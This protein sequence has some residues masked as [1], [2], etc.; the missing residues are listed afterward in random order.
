LDDGEWEASGQEIAQFQSPSRRFFYLD[1]NGRSSF[2][3]GIE[4]QS[5]SRRFFY[6]DLFVLM[7]IAL[8][9]CRFNRLR[10]DSFIWTLPL[11]AGGYLRPTRFQSPSRRFFYLDEDVV[12]IMGKLYRGFQ[13]PSRRFFY[14]DVQFVPPVKGQPSVNEHVSIAFEAILLFGPTPPAARPATRACFNRL[15]GD[16]FI[17]TEST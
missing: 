14:L 15:R 2:T 3:V 9:A 8:S 17:W 10:G 12:E 5:P 11:L 4:F 1:G 7:A 16:S 6:L 13:S